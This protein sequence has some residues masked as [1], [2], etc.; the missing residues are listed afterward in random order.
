[1]KSLPH[2]QPASHRTPYAFGI[3][4]RLFLL[5]I[6]PV[7]IAN[8]I[9]TWHTIDTR[10]SELESSLQLTTKLT[11]ENLARV[12]DFAIYTGQSDLLRTFVDAT[13][14]T[15]YLVSV[16]FLDRN[17]DLLFATDPPSPE[18]V[19][20]IKAGQVTPQDP[21]LL[22]VERPVYLSDIDVDD[23]PDTLAGQGSPVPPGQSSHNGPLQ[24][25]Q[26]GSVVVTADRSVVNTQ[27]QKILFTH[28]L[29]SLGVLVGAAVL[30]Y[31]LSN[32]VVRPIT[33]MT[34]AVRE[35]EEGN[36]EARLQPRGNDELAMLAQGINHMAATIM[37]NRANLQNKVADATQQLQSLLDDLQQKNRELDKAR[38]D[39]EG[40]DRAK[41][42]FLAQMS[43]ELR[44][45]ITAIQGF[46]RLLGESRL[47]PSEKRYCT[48]IQQASLQLLQLIDDI[49]DITRLQSG[50]IELE[51][52]P[53]NLLDC[54]ESPV[55]LMAPSAHQK[56][57]ELI[58]DLAPDLPH[59]LIGDNLRIRQ[60]VYNLVSNAIKFTSSGEVIVRITSR[61]G[62]A[63][64]DQARLLIQV[65]DT[66]IGIPEKQ[67]ALI[68]EP[69]SQADNS[70]SRR[71]GGSGLGLTIVRN[72]VMLMDGNLHVDSTT[73]KG[74]TFAVELPLT[75]SALGDFPHSP[76]AC[77]LLFDPHPHSR[78]ALERLLARFVDNIES[79][80]STAD[81]EIGG[82]EQEPDLI[83]YSI[84]VAQ[85]PGIMEHH[86]DYLRNRFACPLVIIAPLN[87]IAPTLHET[88][89]GD[90]KPVRFIDKPPTL[91]EL[92]ALLSGEEGDTDGIPEPGTR[93]S[94]SILVAE[95]NEFNRL[96]LATFLERLGSNITTVTNGQQAIA[97]CDHQA[98]DLILMDVHMPEVN[99]ISAIKA[100]R[101]GQGPNHHTPIVMLTADI[102]QQ[103][104]NALF[105]A[106]ANDLLFKPIDE[107]KLI[108]TLQRHL[109][110]PAAGS[111]HQ[112]LAP[113]VDLSLF[114]QEVSKLTD[115]ARQAIAHR[116]EP[117]LRESLHQ[118]L[119]IAGVFKM[120]YLERAVRA[121]H[122]AVKEQHEERIEAA[123]LTLSMEVEQL[124][125]NL[126]Q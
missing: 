93:L 87:N 109:R 83:L 7:V 63:V 126:P 100:I 122:V 60:I 13:Q 114:V 77:V 23:Y 95:D 86:V 68:F 85:P 72:L 103:E 117:T 5:C 121:L 44:T 18:W 59:A 55:V 12:S 9:V 94:A 102:L 119:G 10:R 105:E 67:R 39:A 76:F 29:I 58:L 16:I 107:G 75:V 96:L 36:F 104:E 49:L 71:F 91:R 26:L 47:T 2:T 46:V 31:L 17:R 113:S 38:R 15:P 37:E 90:G 106:G 101:S 41:T 79:C 52:A 65:I 54:V 6:I 108:S 124:R 80:E 50:G 27:A 8:I 43:H 34:R 73:G 14:H 42:D 84:P 33:I 120:T 48:I 89:G 116:D 69:F 61:G 115:S 11:A 66:G 62:T 98:F 92:A 88:L 3:R 45:P 123:M 25:S 110:L 82:G 99:G 64:G 81:L 30:T 57:L 40:A 28:L 4:T 20:A 35:L 112:P 19:M 53:F 22:V 97:I 70:I 32:T 51:T 118:L 24:E 1:M 74:T 111:D 78:H 125:R 21:N 56:G